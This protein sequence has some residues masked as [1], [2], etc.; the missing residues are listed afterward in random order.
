MC[1]ALVVSFVQCEKPIR[2]LRVAASQYKP[3][4]FHGNDKFGQFTKGIELELMKIISK[5]ENL[6]LHF[7]E[8]PKKL[9]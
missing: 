5:K 2:T 7:I 9:Q 1:L 4:I 6:P 8:N 3:F